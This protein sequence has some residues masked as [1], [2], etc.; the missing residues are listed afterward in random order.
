[1]SESSLG[2]GCT[3]NG[4]EKVPESGGRVRITLPSLSTFSGEDSRD[5]KTFNCWVQLLKRHAELEQWSP[6]S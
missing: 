5:N 6:L 4:A 3:L 2:S 1:M